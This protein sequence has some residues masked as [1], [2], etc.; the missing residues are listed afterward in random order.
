M[1]CQ[2]LA[3]R[4]G[5]KENVARRKPPNFAGCVLNRGRIASGHQCFEA[6]Q[7][8]E[9]L[10]RAGQADFSLPLKVTK[11]DKRVVKVV[12]DLALNLDE[13]EIEL[14]SVAG[15]GTTVRLVIPRAG[16][17]VPAAAAPGGTHEAAH[18]HR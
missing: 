1:K 18:S 8:G 12:C 6:W 7:I 17:A 4:V 13:R 9:D 16:P 10:S 2:N 15:R 11:H 5:E 14:E 3:L